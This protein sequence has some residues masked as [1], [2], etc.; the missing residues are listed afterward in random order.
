MLATR[1]LLLIT[2]M[3]LQAPSNCP[4]VVANKP[5][6][7]ADIEG[8][9]TKLGVSNQEGTCKHSSVMDNGQAKVSKTS[10]RRYRAQGIQQ[11]DEQT[12]DRGH[13]RR[14]R[15]ALRDLAYGPLRKAVHFA[16]GLAIE[17]QFK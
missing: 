6:G 14:S 17:S 3:S 9:R 2:D 13:L 12:A 15:A 16:L 4:E 7:S 5:Q 8:N 10:H 1:R 11:R